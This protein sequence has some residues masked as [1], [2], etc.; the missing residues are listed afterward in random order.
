MYSEKFEKAFGYVIANE[1]GYVFD[2]N[3]PGA[4]TRYVISKKAYSSFNIKD[5]ILEQATE[6]YWREYWEEG[7]ID[8]ISD[9]FVAMQ[10]LDFS[11][12]LGI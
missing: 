9:I 8:E 2:K 4:E 10:L 6:I 12:N 11:M 1:G 7:K 3:D 5:L